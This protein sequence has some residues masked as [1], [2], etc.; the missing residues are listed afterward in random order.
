MCLLNSLFASSGES[1]AKV[2]G[3]VTPLPCTALLVVW[4][5]LPEITLH[6]FIITIHLPSSHQLQPSGVSVL[7]EPES[8]LAL[9][10]HCLPFTSQVLDS[11]FLSF[12]SYYKQLNLVIIQGS[13]AIVCST[14]CNL[15]QLLLPCS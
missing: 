2:T 14:C 7:H 11:T 10:T 8:E 12:C 3:V 6:H 13:F 5:H 1:Q 15:Y 9:I 4:M